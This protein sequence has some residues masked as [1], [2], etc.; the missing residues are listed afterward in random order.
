MFCVMMGIATGASAL[1]TPE[2]VTEARAECKQH[3]LRYEELE[4]RAP[5]GSTLAADEKAHE[6][7]LWERSCAYAEALMQE[8]GI[9][10]KSAPPPAA[11]PP[12]PEI[13]TIERRYVPRAQQAPSPPDV[14]GTKARHAD[15]ASPSPQP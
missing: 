13:R 6:Y 3:R 12:A 7:D 15:E 8:A 14:G 10:K 11:P 9:E 5:T 1:P 2:E 4:A